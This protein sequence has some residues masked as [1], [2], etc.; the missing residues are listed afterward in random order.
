MTTLQRIA[1]AAEVR[2]IADY[3]R[4]RPVAAAAVA[5]AIARVTFARIMAERA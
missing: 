2:A 3:E 5:D 1:D 4:T